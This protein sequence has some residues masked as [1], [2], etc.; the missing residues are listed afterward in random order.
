MSTTTVDF[1]V[2]PFLGAAQMQPWVWIFACS[3]LVSF[4]QGGTMGANDVA[5]SFGTSVGSKV[6]TV[7]QACVAASIFISLGAMT[8]GSE[9]AKTV[10]KGIVNY[11]LFADIPQLFCLGMLMASVGTGCWVLFATLVRCP[12][13]TTHSI[14]GS[15][16]GFGLVEFG[17]D[18]VDWWPGVGKIV[19]SWVAAPVFT[20]LFAIA[21]YL[22]AK[23]WF[24]RPLQQRGEEY[25][26]KALFWQ[27]VYMTIVVF[28]AFVTFLIF[29]TFKYNKGGKWVGINLGISFGISVPLAALWF[30]VLHKPVNA[31]FEKRGLQG[32]FDDDQLAIKEKEAR[33]N[34]DVESSASSVHE[35]AVNENAV[36]ADATGAPAEPGHQSQMSVVSSVMLAPGERE[37]GLPP[38]DI[39]HPTLEA[40]FQFGQLLSACYEAIAFGAND[41]GNAAGTLQA[42]FQTIETATVTA[43]PKPVYWAM[44]YSTV[45]ILAGLWLL[46]HK[47]MATIGRNITLMTPIRGLCAELATAFSVLIASYLG[48]PVSTTHCSVG[49]VIGV[50]LMETKGYRKVNWKLIGLVV[51]SWII[52]LPAA[53]GVSAGL[54][55][56]A[57][58][59]TRD[60]WFVP[61]ADVVQDGGEYSYTCT[62]TALTQ[63]CT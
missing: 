11:E 36:P 46:G 5:N 52:T 30:F 18:G 1:D 29:T 10:G 23:Y 42:I 39:W 62:G 41:L 25:L 27:R 19:I 13:S 61:P 2:E 44:A 47:V 43:K 35:A 54:Y 53:G 22:S 59:S 16:I 40:R 56:A 24:L 45:G 14:V 32:G 34:A 6:L 58:A 8:I 21:F 17:A 38:D 20:G 33:L 63:T 12:V 60:Q 26:E 37:D 31:F 15:V 55:A 28:L 4:W 7:F 50:G 3:L 9:V 48:I 49:G 51:L 57:R